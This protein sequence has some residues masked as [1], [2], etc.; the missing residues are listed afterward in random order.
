MAAP[1]L[2]VL[3]SIKPLPSPKTH[4]QRIDHSTSG[5]I[6]PIGLLA[7]GL[8]FDFFSSAKDT[9][10]GVILQGVFPKKSYFSNGE[11]HRYHTVRCPGFWIHQRVLKRVDHR[12]LK[13]GC[14]IFGPFR[15]IRFSDFTAQTLTDYFEWNPLAIQTISYL[16]V[17]VVIVYVLSLLAKGL[18]KITRSVSL[19]LFNKFL[20]GIFGVLKWGVLMSVA[21]FFVEKLN[22]W[23]S[24]VD[25]QILQNAMLYAPITQLGEFLF[26]WGS[27]W[28]KELPREFI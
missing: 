10:F 3:P 19:G 7:F 6:V 13:L 16:L 11:C 1:V 25:P 20:G 22:E 12:G 8:C 4:H 5:S 27:E 17:F 26:S 15:A 28:S 18:T 23:I 14:T 2:E 21:L 9:G 24:L